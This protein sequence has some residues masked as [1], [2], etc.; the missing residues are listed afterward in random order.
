[1]S[2]GEGMGL[3]KGEESRRGRIRRAKV[4][5]KKKGRE[6]RGSAK[7]FFYCW[8]PALPLSFR[9]RH[10]LP[11]DSRFS[12]L[13]LLSFRGHEFRRRIDRRSAS[14]EGWSLSPLALLLL[15]LLLLPPPPPPTTTTL[16]PASPLFLLLAVLV[17]VDLKTRRR[18]FPPSPFGRGGPDS[19]SGD[20][21]R[22]RS[23]RRVP[24][25]EERTEK[26]KK[27]LD[28]RLVGR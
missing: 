7:I 10:F 28:R 19:G 15:L 3:G 24:K 14:K 5:A 25:R 26:G 18:R 22:R 6:E 2:R 27:N 8:P 11:L 17:L 13:V 1:M 20:R 12:V 23:D 21:K 16:L 4:K 9:P